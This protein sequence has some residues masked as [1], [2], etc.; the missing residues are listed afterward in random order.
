ML[1][2][3]LDSR[4]DVLR[5]VLP[6]DVDHVLQVLN[7]H[8]VSFHSIEEI[9]LVL[10]V[11]VQGSKLLDILLCHLS[12]VR[13]ADLVRDDLV[14]PPQYLVLTLYV[15][16][17]LLYLLLEFKDLGDCLEVEVL[18][19]V[20]HGV[21]LEI[22]P[23]ALYLI[24]PHLLLNDLILRVS[25]LNDLLH[26]LLDVFDAFLELFELLLQVLLA[27]VHVLVNVTY[28]LIEVLDADL[29]LEFLVELA[30]QPLLYDLVLDLCEELL[31]QLVDPLDHVI[32]RLDR[33]QLHHL[34]LH[35]HEPCS[36]GKG[37]ES[38]FYAVHPRVYIGLLAMLWYILL[39]PASTSFCS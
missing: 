5:D 2:G 23:H 36:R 27:L 19:V 24:E 4:E 6:Q 37:R 9:S 8:E 21:P 12:H 7:R 22:L 11:V 34:L 20:V 1:S 30:P 39:K 25:H 32:H 38:R 26:L 29:V 28:R 14:E 13:L 31:G 35:S 18:K 10:Q 3:S 15:M 33:R 16:S 17:V